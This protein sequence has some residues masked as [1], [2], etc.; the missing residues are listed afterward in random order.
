MKNKGSGL[1]L[2]IAN[3]FLYFSFFVL[4]KPLLYVDINC[5]TLI[6]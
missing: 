1:K 3:E 2:A 6:L 5:F 4:T